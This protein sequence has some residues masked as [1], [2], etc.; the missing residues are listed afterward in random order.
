V[1][2]PGTPAGGSNIVLLAT[3][4]GKTV[5]V[6]VDI[7]LKPDMGELLDDVG[8]APSQ[9]RDAHGAAGD[10]RLGARPQERLARIAVRAHAAASC[11]NSSSGAPITAM[12][13]ARIRSAS[14]GSHIRDC[15][16][17]RVTAWKKKNRTKAT[18]QT[19][20]W[21]NRVRERLG[22]LSDSGRALLIKEAGNACS[23]CGAPDSYGH[24][25]VFDHI[26]PTTHP[27]CSNAIWNRQVLCN[28]CNSRKASEIIDYRK[29]KHYQIR[30]A[31]AQRR[32]A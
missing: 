27:R 1:E 23:C 6:Q 22:T 18:A 24:R 19:T 12:V 10:P 16:R 17:A 8:P 13:P 2:K 9:A 31:P 28:V 11:S 5:N 26:L 14:P 7:A 4:A 25:L 3:V 21:V 30:K 29:I 20:R 15:D 32:A